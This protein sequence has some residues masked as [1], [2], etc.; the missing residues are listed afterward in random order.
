MF[1]AVICEDL[2]L[3][4]GMVVYSDTTIPRD[5]DS[6]ATYSCDTGLTL[7]G[8]DSMRTCTVNGW[9]RTPPTCTSED[10]NGTSNVFT[11]TCDHLSDLI[12]LL[13]LLLYILL[14]VVDCGS[15]FD[16]DNGMVTVTTTTFE[17]TATYTCDTGYTLI[18][19]STRMCGAGGSW[20]LMEP[21]CVGMYNNI[22]VILSS[23]NAFPTAVDCGPLFNP[24]NGAVDTSSGTTFMMTATYICNTGYTLIGANTRTCGAGGMWTPIVP[25]CDRKVI[26]L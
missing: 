12:H 13:L 16:P 15:L 14:T 21:T 25:T 20:T 11:A 17:S 9:D 6:T 2:T 23:M 3:T 8:G 18:G 19:A 22:I 1:V 7:T 4:N 26:V 10:C 5:Q 24:S